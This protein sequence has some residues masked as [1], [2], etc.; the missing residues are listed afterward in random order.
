MHQVKNVSR[1]GAKPQRMHQL[2]DLEQEITERTEDWVFLCFSLFIPVQKI[3][4]HLANLNSYLCALA[5][6]R[7]IPER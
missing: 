5:P 4:L 6:L 1:K 3:C 7:E 2:I